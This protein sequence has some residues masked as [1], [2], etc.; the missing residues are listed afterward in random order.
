MNGFTCGGA[1]QHYKKIFLTHLASV[2]SFRTN[3]LQN[4][5]NEVL[6]IGLVGGQEDV[7]HPDIHLRHTTENFLWVWL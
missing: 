3:N 7:Q 6:K 4:I 1:I 2:Y 5:Q